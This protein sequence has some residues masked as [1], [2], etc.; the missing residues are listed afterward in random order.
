VN[1]DKAAG[2]FKKLQVT[3]RFST[4]V[5]TGV[6][7]LDGRAA[8]M[9]TYPNQNYEIHERVELRMMRALKL[10]VDEYEALRDC[11]LSRFGY[12]EILR[13]RMAH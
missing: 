11:T 5:V 1:R 4:A 7:Q 10:E 9:L 3:P 8:V 6:V 12:L 2:L 13:H